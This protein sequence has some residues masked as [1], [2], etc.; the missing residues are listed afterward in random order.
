MEVLPAERFRAACTR[1]IVHE[2][3]NGRCGVSQCKIC[4][5]QRAGELNRQLLTGTQVSTVAKMAGLSYAAVFNHARRHLPWKSSKAPKPVTCAEKLA[6]LEYQA[7]RLRA[8]AE[9]GQN[10]SQALRVLTAQRGL[11]ELEMRAQGRLDPSNRKKLLAAEPMDGDFRVEF[12]G[13]RAKTVPVA[14]E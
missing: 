2:G 12:V 9:A 1:R 7:A 6:E 10:V 5:S 11:L 3:G 13:G 8:L 4:S 14:S